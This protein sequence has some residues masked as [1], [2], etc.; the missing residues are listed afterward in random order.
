MLEEEAQQLEKD[1]E[2]IHPWDFFHGLSIINSIFVGFEVFT[3][4]VMKS[5]TFWASYP[6][7]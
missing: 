5:I 4:V 7:R 6:R 2:G 3:V 1:V